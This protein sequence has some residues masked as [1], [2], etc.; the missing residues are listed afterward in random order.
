MKSYLILKYPVSN[1]E[2]QWNVPNI[3]MVANM[4]A[5]TFK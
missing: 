1:F 5:A 3:K 2:L 4:V